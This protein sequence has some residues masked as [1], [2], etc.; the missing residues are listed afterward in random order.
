[1][2]RKNI[3]FLGRNTHHRWILLLISVLTMLIC[4][5]SSPLYPLNDWVDSNA[6]FTV[7]KSLW[8]G[9]IAYRD[10]FDHK[11]PL[12]HLL[13]ALG[14]LISPRSFFGM[15]LLEVVACYFTLLFSYRIMCLFT[16]RKS[17]VFI[18]LFAVLVYSSFAMI[19]GGSTEEYCLPFVM[20]ALYV[21][22][23]SLKEKQ[24]MSRKELLAIG[25]T[26]SIIFW[27]KYTLLGIYIGWVIIPL[28]LAIKDKNWK[29]IRDMI[30]IILGSLAAVSLV[31]IGFFLITGAASDLF[32]T[33][34]YCNIFKYQ[35]GG[36]FSFNFIIHALKAMYH[37][38]AIWL[39]F[40][41][42]CVWMIKQK[43]YLILAQLLVTAG[44]GILLTYYMFRNKVYDYYH[45]IYCGFCLFGLIALYSPH[46]RP[47]GALTSRTYAVVLALSCLLLLP[48]CYR[49]S[50]NSYLLM[51]PKS[52]TPQYQFAE[53]INKKPGATV[54][55]YDTIDM[56]IYT[57]TGIIPDNKYFCIMNVNYEEAIAEQNAIMA[58]GSADFIVTRNRE[59][60][61]DL[62]REVKEVRFFFEQGYYEYRL[63]ERKAGH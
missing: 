38:R 5:K 17:I 51:T 43:D 61:S 15:W 49:Q 57:V 1:M 41:V 63:Y 4:T 28:I 13:H 18:P 60:D 32:Y 27:A 42:G 58:N 53:I 29:Y 25:L 36:G 45:V 37:N 19:H 8:S 52:E 16:D 35:S 56:G 23:K 21:V 22:L 48:L 26:S 24:P 34:F 12:L 6:I 7:G 9:K 46:S 33:Y 54:L 44:V 50:R 39:C 14:A 20:Y 3:P 2:N 31:V 59:L 55:T 40:L 10:L 62:Y 47:I 11:G 30:L